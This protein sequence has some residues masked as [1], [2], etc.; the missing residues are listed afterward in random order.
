MNITNKE[1]M[2]ANNIHFHNL[3]PENIYQP[4][5]AFSV[6]K[7]FL[8]N[9]GYNVT[10]KYWNIIVPH[11][12]KNDIQKT[13][14]TADNGMPDSY[15][16][17][18][19]IA[20]LAKEHSDKVSYDKVVTRLFEENPEVMVKD[21][22]YYRDFIE[23]YLNIV[24][25]AIKQEM[26][27]A[28][29]LLHGFTAKFDQWIPAVFW[30]KQIKQANP[31]AYTVIGGF[32]TKEH[33]LAIMKK[34]RDFDFAI[35]GEGEYPL[36]TLCNA[37][38]KKTTDFCKVPRLV[39][40]N[41]DNLLLSETTQSDYFN[42]DAFYPDH[43]DYIDTVEQYKL[44]KNKIYLTIEDSRGC[45]WGKCKFCFRNIDHKYRER[46]NVEIVSE[47]ERLSSIY[48]IYNFVFTGANIIGSKIAKFETFLNMLAKLKEKSGFEYNFMGEVIP[49]NLPENIIKKMA[50]TSFT[51]QIGYE[52]ISDVILGKMK[53]PGRFIDTLFFIKNAQKY[54]LRIMGANVLKNI[55][56]ETSE[57]VIEA[58]NNLPFLRFFLGEHVFEHNHSA[59]YV[60]NKAEFFEEIPAEDK[61][62][63]SRSKTAALLPEKFFSDIDR[64]DLFSYE[65]SIEQNKNLWESFIKIS[66]FYTKNRFYYRMIKMED[67]L[68]YNEYCNGELIKSITFD[69]SL[70]TDILYLSNKIISLN[71]LYVTLNQ[72]H[73]KLNKEEIFSCIN[74][75]QKEFLLFFDKKQNKVLNVL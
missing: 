30:A 42:L 41:N 27:D 68:N 38:E 46:S 24:V 70:Y 29:T 5:A 16:L 20:N 3:I 60:N 64:F 18:P 59:L 58:I 10:V 67:S 75:L 36:L 43:S 57:D 31:E 15:K 7:S 39:Y 34:N 49:K 23:N 72:K 69:N 1:D 4:S 71:D 66:D 2:K 17:L 8:A 52:S 33:A 51:A 44:N 50:F 12:L 13:L 61:K 63:W 22:G 56:N 19:F 6:L 25:K 28:S 53:K 47:V 55:P 45:C 48:K 73:H 11:I 40:R 26:K 74:N 54:G 35:W 14:K 65:T 21:S 9:N 32:Q 37:L 62:Y